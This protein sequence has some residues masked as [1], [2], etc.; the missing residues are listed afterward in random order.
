LLSD[1][2]CHEDTH[3]AENRT[4]TRSVKYKVEKWLRHIRYTISLTFSSTLHNT[5]LNIITLLI[6]KK[7]SYMHFCWTNNSD[8]I[9]RKIMCCTNSYTPCTTVLK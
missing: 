9:P 2:T 6:G 5:C 3:N 1:N 7:T 4:F 8:R